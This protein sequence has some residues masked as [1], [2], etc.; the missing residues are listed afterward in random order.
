VNKVAVTVN[1]SGPCWRCPDCYEVERASADRSNI[2]RLWQTS[3]RRGVWRWRTAVFVRRTEADSQTVRTSADAE[4]V[5]G[6]LSWRCCWLPLR[7]SCQK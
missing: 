7:R 4:P 5:P 1:T 3:G 2:V 6:S